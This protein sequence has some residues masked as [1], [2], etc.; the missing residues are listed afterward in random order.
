L[1]GMPDEFIDG[2]KGRAPMLGDDFSGSD[3]PK[4][5]DEVWTKAGDDY[6]ANPNTVH[7]LIMLNAQMNADGTPV[8]ALAAKTQE[9][10][11]LCREIGGVR[12]LSGHNLPGR[13]TQPYQELSAIM[14][15]YGGQVMPSPKEISASPMRSATRFSRGNIPKEATKRA[16][17]SAMA[18]SMAPGIGARSRPANSCS[19][20]RTKRRRS[21]A[22]PCRSASAAM[23][24]FSPIASCTRT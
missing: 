6:A 22:R 5:W 18:L 23:G 21:L 19:A 20:I 9:I 24:R 4:S 1:R 17:P 7:I 3:W 8:A 13:P 10:E 12:F 15:N 16:A 2:M 11:G 14:M